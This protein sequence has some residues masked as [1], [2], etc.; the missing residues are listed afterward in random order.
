VSGINAG[1]NTGHSVIHSGTVGAALTARTFGS[2]GLAVSLARSDPWHWDTAAECAARVVDW[3]LAQDSR[4]CTFN[5]NVPALP[6]DQ[7]GGFRW[8]EL[9]EFGYFQVAVKTQGRVEFQVSSAGD[10]F[11][12][13]SDTAL[14]AAGFATLS[15]LSPLEAQEPPPGSGP[16]WDGFMSGTGPS[17]RDG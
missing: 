11:D 5:L 14:L 10:H 8:A 2:P 16:R 4:P 15:S 7:L 6:A 1:I 12:E 17:G 3:M 13:R 9:A